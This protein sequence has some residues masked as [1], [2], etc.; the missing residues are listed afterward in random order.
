MKKVVVLKRIRVFCLLPIC[1]IILI[2]IVNATVGVS[3]YISSSYS[4]I[5]AFALTIIAFAVAYP[6]IILPGLIGIIV[7]SVWIKLLNKKK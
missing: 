5:T 1:I 4:G 2:G 6:W 7:T 3:A